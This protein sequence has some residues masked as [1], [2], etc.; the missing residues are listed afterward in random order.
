MGGVIWSNSR[1]GCVLPKVAT[2]YKQKEDY[3]LGIGTIIYG[4]EDR[5]FVWYK[6]LCP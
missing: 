5:R 2:T 4:L 6:D 3:F 1:L